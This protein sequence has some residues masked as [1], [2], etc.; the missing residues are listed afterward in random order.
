MA[1]VLTDTIATAASP[2]I[3]VFMPVRRRSIAA[4]AVTGIT[5]A[6]SATGVNT[7]AIAIAPK[8]TWDNPSPMKEKRL[9]TSVTPS[10]AEHKDISIPAANA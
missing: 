3:F 7:A 6:I 5:T 2:L 8:A 9:R 4:I 1:S 10:N